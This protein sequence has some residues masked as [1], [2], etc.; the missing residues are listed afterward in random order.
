MDIKKR[1]EL[2]YREKVKNN[3][4]A[5]RKQIDKLKKR[6]IK[7]IRKID[8]ENDEKIVDIIGELISELQ[9]FKDEIEKGE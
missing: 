9:R 7:E 4:A 3:C 6:K 5:I 2:E 8:K 1:E